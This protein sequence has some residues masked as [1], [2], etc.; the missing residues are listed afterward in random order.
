MYLPHHGNVQVLRVAVIILYVVIDGAAALRWLPLSCCLTQ[1]LSVP[2]VSFP[3]VRTNPLVQPPEKCLRRFN[4]RSMP[5][6]AI[7]TFN[8]VKQCL[9]LKM[10]CI[11]T[12]AC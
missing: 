6:E 5:N 2:A 9:T 1:L 3:L 11:S 4:V 10:M 7:C 12:L 8:A